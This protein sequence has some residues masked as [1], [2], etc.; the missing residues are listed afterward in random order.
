MRLIRLQCY[1][2]IDANQALYEWDY[3][4]QLV[5]V[6]AL[7]ERAG[8]NDADVD[9]LFGSR[10][11]VERPLLQA[12]RAGEQAVLL[13]DEVDR[14]DDEFEAFLL[15]VLSDFQVTVPELGTIRAEEPPAVI[16]T[17]NRTRELHDALKRRCLYHW[18]DYPT[19]DREVE[20]VA[21]RAPDVSGE[22]ARKVAVAVSRL[23]GL[24]LE[25]RPGIAE[26]IDW[27]RALAVLGANGLDPQVV[28]DTLGSVVKDHDDLVLVRDRVAEVIGD[29]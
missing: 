11:L 28:D 29:G 5:Y 13:V 22:L 25:K 26:T 21:V 8:T 16:V 10:F 2:G 1:E 3:A 9:E 15:E 20:I 7:S 23:R 17:S 14:A 24:D 18:I 6:R 12:L 27:A 19:P 4:R